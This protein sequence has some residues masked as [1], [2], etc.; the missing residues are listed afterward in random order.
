MGQKPQYVIRIDDGY[1]AGAHAWKAV[2]R[3]LATE[4]DHREARAMR[5]R[6]R[7]LGYAA[8]VEPACGPITTPAAD[9]HPQEPDDGRR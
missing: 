8:T 3:A 6:L 2:G 1:Y 7:R 4:M 9:D 5:G